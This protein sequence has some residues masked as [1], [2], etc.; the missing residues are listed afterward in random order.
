MPH[1]S[2][3]T[4]KK[5]SSDVPVDITTFVPQDLKVKFSQ[6]FHAAVHHQFTMN[7]TATI[8]CVVL[9]IFFTKGQLISDNFFYNIPKNQRVEGWSKKKSTR[10]YFSDYSNTLKC[11]DF[12]NS[13]NFFCKKI[14]GFLKYLKP[15]KI[16]SEINWHLMWKWLS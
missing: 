8:L 14:V 2:G 1:Y 3:L 9:L 4:W 16:A 11:S 6:H 10:W 5:V 12:L 7:R 15:R 13:T